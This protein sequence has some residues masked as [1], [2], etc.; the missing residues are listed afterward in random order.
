MDLR[1]DDRIEVIFE[2]VHGS[3][4]YGL[5]RAESDIDLKGVVVGPRS[6]Y[7]GYTAGPE[8]LELSPDHV[9]F[10]IR[11]YVRL[12]AEANPTLLEMLFTDPEHHRIVTEA[13]QLLL[14]HRHAFLSR[15]I[16]NRFG[17]YALSQLKRIKTHRA[18]LLHPPT[19]APMRAEFKLPEH[20]VIPADQLAAAEALLGDERN[21]VIA[22]DV[23]PNFLEL[24]ARERRYK[25]AKQQWSA[26]QSWLRTRNPARSDL[27][28]KFGYDTKHAMH[29]IR[30]QRMGLEALTTGELIVT[31]PDR[32]E[33]LGIRDGMWSYDQLE[34]A[35]DENDQ[36]LR[37]AATNSPLPMEPDTILL[38][39]LCVE[40][41]GRHL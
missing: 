15:H 18:H 19:H 40:I 3:T 25:T 37:S 23:S 28:A 38:E 41:I 27:E 20:T 36:Q 13:G 34:A 1:G 24:L 5:A 12:A 21:D 33:L 35:A 11:K 26:Y 6:W 14:D 39:S 10:D 16:A 4:A 31:R 32:D 17:G 30:L 7:L 22:A 2:T 9:R 29:L 8:Q